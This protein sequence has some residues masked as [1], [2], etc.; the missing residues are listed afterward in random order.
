MW[1]HRISIIFALLLAHLMVRDTAAS[2]AWPFPDWPGRDVYTYSLFKGRG[3][4]Q[5]GGEVATVTNVITDTVR[6]TTVT[7][8]TNITQGSQVLTIT[9]A[10]TGIVSTITNAGPFTNI[11]TLTQYFDVP[12]TNR[13]TNVTTVFIPFLPEGERW[14]FEANVLGTNLI[15]ARVQTPGRALDLVPVPLDAVRDGTRELVGGAL[16]RG[17]IHPLDCEFGNGLRT[18]DRVR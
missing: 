11:Y 10:T 16:R 9:N 17:P 4:V 12:G 18:R 14:L 5:S 1:S 3:F 13:T 6:V 15:S 2:A 8:L 7:T